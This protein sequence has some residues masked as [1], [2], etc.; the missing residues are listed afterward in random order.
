MTDSMTT[1]EQWFSRVRASALVRIFILTWLVLWLQV[2]ISMI[3]HTID[4]RRDRRQE[5]VT[6]LT[7]TWGATQIVRGPFLVVPTVE[8]WIETNEKGEPIRQER[9]SARWILPEELGIDGSV[10]SE[11]RRRGIFDVPLYVARLSIAGKFC[12]SA[13]QEIAHRTVETR[14]QD[15]TLVLGISD[16]RAL[17][18]NVPLTWGDRTLAMQPGPGPTTLVDAGVNV[19]ISLAGVAPGTTIPFSMPLVVAGSDAL[20]IFPAGSTTT[21]HLT[22]AWPDPGFSGAYLP[23]ART[24]N[25]QGFDASWR[26]LELARNVPALWNDGEVPIERIDGTLVGVDLL[27]P[28]D[29]YRTTERAVKYELLFV[30]LTFLALFLF[31]LI[32]GV[33]IHPVQYG[34]VG[35]ALCLFYLLL[36]SLTEHLGFGTAYALAACAIGGLVTAYARTVLGSATRTAGIAGL[37]AGLYLFLFVLLQIQDYALLAGALG[38]F[39]SLAAVMRLTRHV[40]WYD[41]NATLAPEPRG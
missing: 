35:L 21:L 22:S 29:A 30:G 28:V 11:I 7:R 5:A 14:W 34:L 19:P 26:V 3:D 32:G 31:E 10:E 38:L 27:S 39:L 2:P 40:N 13:P 23:T 24:V 36:L 6:D 18:E 25:A 20:R 9:W 12:V 17:R 8:R 33:R 16:P 15:A 1:L 37:L 41:L 4:E